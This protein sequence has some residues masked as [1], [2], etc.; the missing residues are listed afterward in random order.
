M[1][2]FSLPSSA[3]LRTGAIAAVLT[4][5]ISTVAL[6]QAHAIEKRHA[7]Y[8][9]GGNEFII[10]K[11][12]A[13]PGKVYLYAYRRAGQQWERHSIVTVKAGTRHYGNSI[14]ERIYTR[15][16]RIGSISI[17]LD[18]PLNTDLNLYPGR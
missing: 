17:D 6:N 8:Q 13:G 9:F 14:P 16:H 1:S 10:R 15:G 18:N 12:P 11:Q 7:V 3:V 5:A 2:K 4:A